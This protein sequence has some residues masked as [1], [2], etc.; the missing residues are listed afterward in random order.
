MN[1]EWLPVVGYESLYLVSNDGQVMS[2]PRLQYQPIGGVRQI[3]GKVLKSPSNNIGYSQ[4][5][6]CGPYDRKNVKVHRLV[7]VAF[8]PNP[9]NL[10][11]VNHKD[12]NKA[13]NSVNNL[14]WVT[15][16]Q[17][18]KHATDNGVVF[19]NFAAGKRS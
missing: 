5:T 14:E 15:S 19:G 6:L 10:P 3:G 16:K 7:A 2:L 1:I 18:K 8:I 9:L 13:N 11:E 4:V 12:L 17:N